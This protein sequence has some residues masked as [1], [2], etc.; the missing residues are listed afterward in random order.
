M[1]DASDLV[2]LAGVTLS[3]Y[4]Y[5]RV[6]WQRDYAKKMSYSL[7]NLVGAILMIASL[8]H[9]WNLPGFVSCSIWSFMSAYGVY[10]CTKYIRRSKKE[11]LI[12]SGKTPRRHAA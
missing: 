1:F 2:G 6:Q 4:C 12:R 5:V 3:T 8:L 10:R 7:L 11:V 9:N